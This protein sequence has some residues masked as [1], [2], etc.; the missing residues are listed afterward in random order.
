MS[1]G[2]YFLFLFS[3]CLGG[4]LGFQVSRPKYVEVFVQETRKWLVDNCTMRMGCHSLV[5]LTHISLARPAG[6]Q[7]NVLRVDFEEG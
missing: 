6:P 7:L 5:T 1:Y 3:I 2:Y 4:Q